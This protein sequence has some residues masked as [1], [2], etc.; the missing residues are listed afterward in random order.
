MH[1]LA[2]T[3]SVVRRSPIVQQLAK[4]AKVMPRFRQPRFFALITACVVILPLLT[5]SAQSQQ[6]QALQT[7][8]T[9]PAGAQPIGRLPGTQRLQLATS[10]PL[11]NEAQLDTFLQQLEDPTSP[12]Y[13]K[14]LTSAQFTEQFGPTVEQYRDSLTITFQGNQFML[15]CVQDTFNGIASV[16][17]DG[18]TATNVDFYASAR[19]GN[20]LLWTSLT[21]TEGTHTFQPVVTGQK[22]PNAGNNSGCP[23]CIAVDRADIVS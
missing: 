17:I 16:S 14:Y 1:V 8:A 9:A 11:R 18:A 15:Y 12:N 22:N 20:V 5:T 3:L 19:K 21:L 6:R 2:H 7:H 10:R 13:H 23:A 4:D